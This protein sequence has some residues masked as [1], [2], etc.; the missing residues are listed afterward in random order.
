MNK[1]SFV[2]G[3]PESIL[4]FPS[5]RDLFEFFWKCLTFSVN[6]EYFRSENKNI[7]EKLTNL[8]YVCLLQS[9]SVIRDE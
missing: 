6:F 1:P 5:F 2:F 7:Q 8:A 3:I 9:S 4:I